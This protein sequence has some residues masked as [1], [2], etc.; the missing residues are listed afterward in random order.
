MISFKYVTQNRQIHGHDG[1]CELEEG[2][3]D[4]LF[5]S[6]RVLV[7]DDEKF[8]RWIV[9]VVAQQCEYT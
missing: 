1:S 4:L 8:W 9:A 5:N 6:H 7:W 3:G 2:N